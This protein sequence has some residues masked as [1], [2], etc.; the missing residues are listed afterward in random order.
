VI[1][2]ELAASSAEIARDRGGRPHDPEA[3]R[4]HD[5]AAEQVL[6]VVAVGDR[7]H[8]AEHEREQH[9]EHHRL[10]R[11]VEQLLGDLADVREMAAGHHQAVGQEV[12]RHH[13]ASASGLR[14][15]VIARNT[16]SSVTSR[17]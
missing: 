11:D 13:A 10:E 12:A 17:R 4:L 8:A 16:S 1:P 6:A 9:R 2:T 15:V 3:Q 14:A 5:H 7:D